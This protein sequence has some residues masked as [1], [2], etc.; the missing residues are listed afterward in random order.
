MENTNSPFHWRIKLIL[1]NVVSLFTNVPLDLAIK[2]IKNSLIIY[3]KNIKISYD[4]FIKALKLILY[5]TFFICI[6]KIDK[7]TFGTFMGLSLFFI[8][9]NII[10]QDLQSKAIIKLPF[11]PFYVRYVDDMALVAFPSVCSL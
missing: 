4:E 3:Q 7:Q 1:L 5:S 9:V 2:S 6:Q 10:L 8:I 11:L